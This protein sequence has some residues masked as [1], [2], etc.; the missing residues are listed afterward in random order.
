MVRAHLNTL[1][2]EYQV[3]YID[4]RVID[5]HCSGYI[6]DCRSVECE[7]RREEKIEDILSFVLAVRII[8]AIAA[9]FRCQFL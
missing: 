6:V 2:I 8:L 9:F 5:P 4:S 3:V 7:S 1:S